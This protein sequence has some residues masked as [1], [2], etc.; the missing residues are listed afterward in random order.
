MSWIY[1]LGAVT[2]GCS[3]AGAPVLGPPQAASKRMGRMATKVARFRMGDLL[4]L[5]GDEGILVS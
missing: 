1:F 3:E 5:N 2:G 4:I